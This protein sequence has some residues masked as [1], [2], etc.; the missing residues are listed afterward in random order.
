MVN[1]AINMYEKS[2]CL[3]CESGETD[4]ERE[5]ESKSESERVLAREK[6]RERNG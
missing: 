2:Y 3:G 1:E 6:E 5:R 4:D